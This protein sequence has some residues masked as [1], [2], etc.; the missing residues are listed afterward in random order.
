[1]FG[2]LLYYLNLDFFG[3]VAQLVEQRLFKTSYNPSYFTSIAD[4][5]T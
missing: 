3:S 5:R 2:K 1:M 4:F